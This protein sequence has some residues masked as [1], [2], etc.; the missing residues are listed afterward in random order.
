MAWQLSNE[1]RTKNCTEYQ[2]WIDDIGGL[3][4]ELD[5][6]H[7]VSLGNE[8]TITP[9]AAEASIMPQLDY[10][11]FHCWAQNWEWYD[12]MEPDLIATFDK[13]DDYLEKNMKIARDARKP[14]VLEEFGLSRDYGNYTYNSSSEFKNHYYEHIFQYVAYEVQRGG[15]LMGTNFWAWAGEGRPDSPGG[16]WR[17]GDQLIGDPPHEP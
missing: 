7:L 2:L 17:P 8:G 15:Y 6:N 1:P 3:I 14:I 4:K 10:L 11:T 5:Q 16:E 9:C 13:V 12:P